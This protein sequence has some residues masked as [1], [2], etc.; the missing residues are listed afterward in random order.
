MTADD[1]RRAV[2]FQRRVSFPLWLVVFTYLAI[3]KDWNLP[4]G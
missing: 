3:S 1:W 2:R 4:I